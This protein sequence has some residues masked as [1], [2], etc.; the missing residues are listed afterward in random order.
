MP[1][2]SAIAAVGAMGCM[3]KHAGV[4]D[5]SMST[6]AKCSVSLSVSLRARPLRRMFSSSM[7]RRASRLDGSRRW[8]RFLGVAPRRPPPGTTPWGKKNSSSSKSYPCPWPLAGSSRLRLKCAHDHWNMCDFGRTARRGP[9]AS[10][11]GPLN[12]GGAREDPFRL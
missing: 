9:R 3:S 6:D 12:G 1:R 5:S 7:R 2:S 11:S 10:P 4:A 8:C